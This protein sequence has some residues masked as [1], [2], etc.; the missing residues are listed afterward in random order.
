MVIVVVMLAPLVLVRNHQLLRGKSG[1][2]CGAVV[3]DNDGFFDAGR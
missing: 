1:K 2:N 3:G